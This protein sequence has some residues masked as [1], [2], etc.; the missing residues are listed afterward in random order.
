[1]STGGARVLK[2]GW[3]VTD[4]QSGVGL[5]DVLCARRSLGSGKRF[6]AVVIEARF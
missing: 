3:D 5:T 2:A 4:R 6:R 1:M